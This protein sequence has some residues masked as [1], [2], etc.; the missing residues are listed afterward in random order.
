MRPSTMYLG[1]KRKVIVTQADGVPRQDVKGRCHSDRRCTLIGRE[2]SLSFRPTV[3]LLTGRERSLS[4]TLT[5]YLLT[6]RE[7][8]L[9]FRPTMY[10][11]RTRKVFVIQT[12]DVPR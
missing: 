6:G 1:R 4:F 7:R 9:S 2:R 3:Y 8:S 12:D 5:V 11:N 10:L